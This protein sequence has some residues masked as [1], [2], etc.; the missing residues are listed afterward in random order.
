MTTR[1][2]GFSTRTDAKPAEAA[3]SPPPKDLP[4]EFP[5]EMARLTTAIVMQDAEEIVASFRRLGF[6]T[7]HGGSESLLVLGEA[8]LGHS[9]KEQKSYAD[10]KMVEQF[11][12]ERDVNIRQRLRLWVHA[13]EQPIEAG[14]ENQ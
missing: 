12:H 2:P 13:G 7:K 14:E 10:P 5:L 8:M 6:V 4:P 11:N 3:R 1:T 9:V